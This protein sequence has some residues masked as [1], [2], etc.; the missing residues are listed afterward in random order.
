MLLN[1]NARNAACADF[2]ALGDESTQSRYVFV[3]NNAYGDR[4]DGRLR[5]SAL[6]S[7][8]FAAVAAGLIADR[9]LVNRS[10]F[11]FFGLAAAAIITMLFTGSALTNWVVANIIV[12]FVAVYAIRA[13]Y[14]ALVEQSQC[15]LGVTGT[16]VGL[17]SLIGYTN[18]K[19]LYHS[20]MRPKIP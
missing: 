14:F 9:W 13:V 3:V 19:H 12:T 2:S 6:H 18:L 10:I 20:L 8:W 16:A 1:R 4:L 11:V 15:G 5:L 7:A 17:I